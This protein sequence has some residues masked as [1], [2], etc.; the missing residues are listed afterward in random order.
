[1]TAFN[2]NTQEWTSSTV[3]VFAGYQIIDYNNT[4]TKSV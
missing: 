4:I 3:D 2:K 1:M